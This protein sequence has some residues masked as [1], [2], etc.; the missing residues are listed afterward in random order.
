[1]SDGLTPHQVRK[2]NYNFQNLFEDLQALTDKAKRPVET[3][4]IGSVT[5]VASDQPAKV[6]NSGSK[7]NIVLNF[8]IPTGVEPKITE[9]DI[10]AVIND[11]APTG[12]R[13][14]S[15]TGLSSFWAKV[16]AAIADISDAMVTGVKG[17]AEQSYRRGDVNLTPANIGASP[18]GHTHDAD[19]T[20]SG[21]FAVARIPNL[22]ANKITAGTLA[23][24]RGG[25][26]S[27]NTARAINTVFAGPSSGSAGNASWR[28][29]DAA[30]IPNLDAGKITTGAFGV[31]RIPNLNASKITAGTLGIDRIP[32][33]TPAKGG[34][35]RTTAALS[36][37]TIFSGLNIAHGGNIGTNTAVFNY[38]FFMAT[39]ASGCYCY[40]Y[41]TGSTSSAGNIYLVGGKDSGSGALVI[42]AQ[43]AV[44][45]NGKCTYT[46]GGEHS[47]G[48]STASST[49]RNL[50]GLY[51]LY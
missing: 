14:L 8:E 43:I 10:L 6:T 2:L 31:D 20:V 34:T 26:A 25:T 35:G 45:T 23:L 29:L 50:T 1:M 51:G 4:K 46:A 36:T 38:R 42:L 28:K 33:I 17:N 11:E 24:A 5:M 7:N 47:A 40:G 18:T 19:D 32:T 37:H 39:L 49:R 27:D 30:D 3:L 13:V 22:N 48:S 21:E 12:N 44:A 15:L 9:E 41:R 16:K